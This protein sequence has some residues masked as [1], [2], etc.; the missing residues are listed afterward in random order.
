MDALCNHVI[1]GREIDP[2]DAEYSCC[3]K[4]YGPPI[5]LDTIMC[6]SYFRQSAAVGAN[7]QPQTSFRPPYGAY[8]TSRDP[9]N[10]KF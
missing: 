8:I 3:D 1:A 10:M 4:G 2:T 9:E 6:D 5:E 7:H